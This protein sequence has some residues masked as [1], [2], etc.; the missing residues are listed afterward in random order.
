M[1]EDEQPLDETAAEQGLVLRL[2]PTGTGR[3][4]E[5]TVSMSPGALLLIPVPTDLTIS[6]VRRC[7]VPCFVPVEL[8]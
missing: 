5:I 7:T 8:Y 2:A 4:E 6:G 1:T 3:A